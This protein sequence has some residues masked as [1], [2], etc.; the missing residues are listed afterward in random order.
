LKIVR[1]VTHLDSFAEVE[2]TKII[3]ETD[4]YSIIIFL[5]EPIDSIDVVR[6]SPEVTEVKDDIIEIAGAHGKPRK[7]KVVLL[8]ETAPRKSTT[9]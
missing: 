7:A 3:P 5:R 2:K 4:K 9:D 8:E 6:T 1:L